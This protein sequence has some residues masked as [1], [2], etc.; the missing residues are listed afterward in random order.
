MIEMTKPRKHGVAPRLSRCHIRGEARMKKDE[1]MTN[2]G[3]DLLK[4]L[5]RYNGIPF[6][7]FVP[8]FDDL[9]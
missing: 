5:H 4:T 8:S 3:R 2:D 9:T 7:T 6:V 1:G